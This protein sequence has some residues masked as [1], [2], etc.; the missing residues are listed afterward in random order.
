M[1]GPFWIIHAALLARKG[2]PSVALAKEDCIIL[3]W[4]CRRFS[5]R[6]HGS[7]HIAPAGPGIGFGPLSVNGQS[8]NMAGS[9][10]RS[11]FAQALYVHHDLA[12]QIALNLKILF[13]NIAD[14]IDLL[15][16]QFLCSLVRV[17]LRLFDNLSR[18]RQTDA[19]NIRKREFNFLIIGNV[20]SYNAHFRK[21]RIIS[22]VQPSKFKTRLEHLNLEFFRRR[23][24]RPWRRI[25][26]CFEFRISDFV[27]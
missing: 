13:N 1:A 7:S 11:G 12:T 15:G 20:G 22:K 8:P 2:C 6:P 10:I 14:A 21:I 16:K 4:T 24:I 3:C 17:D 9:P 23:R 25:L 18:Q 26:I 19:V 27:F 5:T